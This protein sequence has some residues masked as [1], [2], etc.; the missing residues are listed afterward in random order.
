MKSEKKVL[1]ERLDVQEMY[2]AINNGQRVD[3]ATESL[4]GLDCLPF[5]FSAGAGSMNVLLP[6][7]LF[8]V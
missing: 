4:Q 8:R 1:V 2:Y 5:E 3:T 6:E 7:N